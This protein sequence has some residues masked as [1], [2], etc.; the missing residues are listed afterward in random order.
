MYSKGISI[1]VEADGTTVTDFVNALRG[2]ATVTLVVSFELIYISIPL[3]WSK[4]F[5]IKPNQKSVPSV[6]TWPL[7][8]KA[9]QTNPKKVRNKLLN[10]ILPL[11][12]ISYMNF[13]YAS[14]YE[15]SLN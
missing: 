8:E 5:S 2:I 6:V 11:A 10:L 9:R 13:K 14:F 3:V 12:V 4:T 15:I 7:A 1:R